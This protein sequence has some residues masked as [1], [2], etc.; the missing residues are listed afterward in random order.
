LK[1]RP[2]SSESPADY[3]Q[4]REALLT[5][6]LKEIAAATSKTLAED[7]ARVRSRLQM[8]NRRRR[9]RDAVSPYATSI[10]CC[11]VCRIDAVFA[12]ILAGL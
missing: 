9:S 7:E 2:A 3:A 8:R 6:G 11:A 12:Q 10:R 1:L 4:A 5:G